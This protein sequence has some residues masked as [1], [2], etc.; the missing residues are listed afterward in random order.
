MSRTMATVTAFT[1]MHG[2]SND[3]VVVDGPLEPEPSEVAALCDR[4]TGVG[5][6]GLLAVSRGVAGGT[7][8]MQYWNADG[9]T[10][11]MCGNG[12][13][14]VVRYA[15]DRGL[16]EAEELVVETP[17]GPRSARVLAN[18]DIAVDLGP[19]RVH[20]SVIELH[21]RPWTTVDVGNPHAVTFVPDPDDT[22]VTVEGP[23]VETDPV[24][25]EGTNV[26]FVSVEGDHIDMRVWERGVGETQA[27]GTGMVAAAA[28]ARL[29]RPE[30]DDWQVTVPGG[31]GRVEFDGDRVWLIGPAVTVFE[32]VVAQ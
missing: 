28:A 12:F 26:E 16:T 21:G 22:D 11:E 15:L 25:T 3:F 29:R 7:V 23:Q 8:R 27:C 24:F 10:A 13:R 4:R 19:V 17:V 9:S 5:A 32:G 31:T 18:G 30:V 2:L 20:E 6:D 14:C 1:K